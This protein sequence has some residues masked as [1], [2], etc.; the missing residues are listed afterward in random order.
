MLTFNYVVCIIKTV[1]KE[2]KQVEEKHKRIGRPPTG[3]KRDKLVSFRLTDDEYNLIKKKAE[4]ENL[5]INKYV[6]KKVFQNLY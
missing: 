6:F 1:R 2:V 3:L 5:S 4:Q